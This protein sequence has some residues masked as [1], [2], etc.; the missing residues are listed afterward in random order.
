MKIWFRRVEIEDLFS[1]ELEMHICKRYLNIYIKFYIILKCQT[2]LQPR[3]C[4]ESSI[5]REGRHLGYGMYS[6]P[7]V[8]V[9]ATVQ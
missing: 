1:I 3:G 8:H 6:V 2:F 4:T 7:D 5:W 9:G